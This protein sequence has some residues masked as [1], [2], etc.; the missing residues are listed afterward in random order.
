MFSRLII[1][2]CM[3]ELATGAEQF[4]VEDELVRDWC[5]RV[6]EVVCGPA[7]SAGQARVIEDKLR[8][9]VSSLLDDIAAAIGK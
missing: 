2:S 5:A 6:T 3:R 1:L 7:M 8:V 9:L 4:G